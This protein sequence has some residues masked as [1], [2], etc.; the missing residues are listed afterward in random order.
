MVGLLCCPQAF[1]SLLVYNSYDTQSDA[2][3]DA[4]VQAIAGGGAAQTPWTQNI[5]GNGFTLTG[6]SG[7][8]STGPV[9]APNLL[10]PYTTNLLFT[11]QYL[12]APSPN[13][14]LDVTTNRYQTYIATASYT[15]TGISGVAAGTQGI[16]SQ[17]VS[18]SAGSTIVVTLPASFILIGPATSAAVSIPAGKCA[19]FSYWVNAF[20]TN[21]MNAVQQ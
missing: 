1:G 17:M 10:A 4:H 11:A 6:V 19:V 21:A 5:N 20:G 7:I 15:I 16:L 12:T 3:V 8:T 18:N 13:L 2:A 9:I 14:V